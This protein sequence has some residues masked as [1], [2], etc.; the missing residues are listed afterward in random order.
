M[1]PRDKDPLT[2]RPLAPRIEPQG[3]LYPNPG[4]LSGDL[5]YPEH[6]LPPQIGE[7]RPGLSAFGRLTRATNRGTRV[8]LRYDASQSD[9]TQGNGS[10]DAFVIQ[11]NDLDACPL[12]ITIGPPA[13][14]PIPFAQVPDNGQNLSDA[15]TNL[16]IQAADFPGTSAPIAWPPLQLLLEWGVHG[17][18]VAA[19][20][21]VINGAVINLTASWLRG[22]V[23]AALSEGIAGTSAAYIM[24]AFVGPAVPGRAGRAQRTVYL[25]NV[26][27]L[28]ESDVFPIPRFARSAYVITADD[29]ATPAVTV[30]TLRYWQSPDGTNNVGNVVQ[31]GNQPLPFPVPSGAAYAS[32]INGTGVTS[33]IAIVYDLAIA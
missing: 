12:T 13:V 30:A 10:T 23:Q 9:R 2:G 3:F 15:Q 22:R 4:P 8:V 32:V 14:V 11:G 6:G 20:V 18:S 29:S 28:A 33:R 19:T 26:V 1:P 17:T 16:E 24:N 27:S 21:D 7:D 25:G 31:A 5:V